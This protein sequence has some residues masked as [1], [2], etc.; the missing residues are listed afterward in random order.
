[1]VTFFVR[2]F[3]DPAHQ[4]E[5]P[6]NILPL[7]FWCVSC[8]IGIRESPPH[9]FESLMSRASVVIPGAQRRENCF[10]QSMTQVATWFERK[11]EFAFPVEL[12]PNLIVRLRGTPA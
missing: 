6:G 7:A 2:D 3:P 8:G 12:Y 11:F 9:D 5:V 10:Y 1:M 4:H